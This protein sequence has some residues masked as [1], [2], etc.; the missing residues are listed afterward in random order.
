MKLRVGQTLKSTVDAV[1][2]IVVKPALSISD[3]TGG[4]SLT[5]DDRAAGSD[6]SAQVVHYRVMGNSLPTGPLPGVVSAAVSGP[7]E[8]IELKAE[9]GQFVN[10]GTEGDILLHAYSSGDQVVGE[11]PVALAGKESTAGTQ[12]SMLNGTLA[13]AWKASAM[14]ALSSGK[15]PVTLTVTVK[16]V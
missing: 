14:Q 16:D 3:D 2:V 10:N 7:P 12:A 5:F 13:V 9:V 15:Y 11:V 6:S 1:T 4:A 8:G